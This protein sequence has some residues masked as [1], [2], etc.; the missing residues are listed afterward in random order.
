MLELNGDQFEVLDVVRDAGS[1]PDTPF[2]LYVTR[3]SNT[4]ERRA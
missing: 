3:V 4:D 2:R 1:T